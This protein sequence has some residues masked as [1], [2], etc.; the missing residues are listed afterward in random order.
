VQIAAAAAAA[1]AVRAGV[2]LVGDP[3][4]SKQAESVINTAVSQHGKVDGIVNCVGSIVLKSAHTT[5][6]AD[7]DQVRRVTR[8]GGRGAR[9][10]G[11]GERGEGGGIGCGGGRGERG[12]GRSDVYRVHDKRRCFCPGAQLVQL[13]SSLS[14]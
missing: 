2:P 12:G 9:G 10:N 14:C 5:S 6:D 11:G 7:F 4:D 8:G 1:A 13:G 3:L